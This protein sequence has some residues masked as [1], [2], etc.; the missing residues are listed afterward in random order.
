[1]K[2]LILLLSMMFTLFAC[3]GEMGPMGPQGP[4]GKPGEPGYGNKWY[5]T[6]FTIKSDQWELVGEPGELK[7]Y[8]MVVLDLHQ[9]TE[10]IFEEGTVVGYISMGENVKNGLPYVMHTAEGGTDG[11]H[12]W[13]QTYDFDFA[14]GSVAFYATFSDFETQKRPGDETF[15]IVLMW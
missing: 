12:Y 9:L 8:Y 10:E 5:T 7:S 13:T 15:H 1:M 3:E 11:N 2:K 4:E 6:S 14:P